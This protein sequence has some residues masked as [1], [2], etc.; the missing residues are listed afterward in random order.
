MVIQRMV[1]IV[2]EETEVPGITQGLRR[3]KQIAKLMIRPETIKG[4]VKVQDNQ[5]NQRGALNGF[6]FL[7]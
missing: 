3:L 7:F 5:A 6:P 1:N 4:L 2:V